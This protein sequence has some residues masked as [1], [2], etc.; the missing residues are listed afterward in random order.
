[1]GLIFYYSGY[2]IDWHTR[3][4]IQLGS[5]SVNV[6]PKDS[7][8]Y[9]DGQLLNKTTP[10]IF[11]SIKP[12]EYSLR[13]EHTGN[14][15]LEFPIAVRSNSTTVMSELFLP[16]MASPQPTEPPSLDQTLSGKQLAD[17]S[18]VKDWPIWSISGQD[19]TAVITG[20]NRQLSVIEEGQVIPLK[21]GVTQLD[22]NSDLSQVVF[23]ESGTAWMI[24]TNFD[25]KVEFILTR[26]STPFVD[27]QLVPRMQA[28]ILADEHSIQ[29][30]EVGPQQTVSLIK[31][32]SGEHLKRVVVDSSGQR[33]YY[34]DGATWYVQALQTP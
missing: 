32:A 10:A 24:Y 5:V 1:M 19:P 17:L 29:L 28:V 25:P 31:I 18:I 7:Q 23:I 34:L 30:V 6:F 11:N 33:V 20:A 21:S 2:R 12:G 22:T 26:Q 16:A 9:L 4:I 15:P 13:L 14:S 3:K 8:V 27:L